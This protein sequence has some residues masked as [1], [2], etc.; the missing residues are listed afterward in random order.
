MLVVL[1]SGGDEVQGVDRRHQR[2][3]VLLL[4]TKEMLP[5]TSIILVTDFN[6]RL[7]KLK[8]A[9]LMADQE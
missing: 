7:V 8:A 1:N 2:V 5:L 6:A 4:I 9:G 3:S